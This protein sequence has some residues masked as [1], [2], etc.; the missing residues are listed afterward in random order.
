MSYTIQTYVSNQSKNSSDIRK[1]KQ[2]HSN[3]Q[4]K[5]IYPHQIEPAFS[6]NRPK[7]IKMK[8]QTATPNNE[9]S[10]S[11]VLQKI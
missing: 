5:K 3:S 6:S 2:P 7:Q 10:A 11:A 4:E 9:L 8:T 1:S